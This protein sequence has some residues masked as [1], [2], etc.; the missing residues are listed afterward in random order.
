M[1]SKTIIVSMGLTAIA[2]AQSTTEATL[3]LPDLCVTQ[4]APTVT[5]V[6]TQDSLTTYSYSCSIDSAAVSSASAKASQ[7]R[8]SAQ[9][10]ASEVRASLATML[11][12][13]PKE[14]EKPD[15]KRWLAAMKQ[16]DSSFECYGL[17]AFDACIPWEIT[18]G[19]SFWAVHYT[20]TNVV[21]VEQECT[22][23]DGGVASGPA[24][25]TAS[26]RLDPEIWGDG[27]GSHTETFA[28][29]EVDDFY[30]RNTVMVTM[31]GEAAP[32]AT[33]AGGETGHGKS[34]PLVFSSFVAF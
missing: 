16:R 9:N 15:D 14:S 2:T 24:T 19:P 4:S 18:Q 27:D 11:P 21:G 3:L 29:T 31:G 8:E 22:F 12:K 25:C 23:G 5:V 1:V 10:K 17:D 26:G 28:K 32:Q 6:N 33:T 30:I 7:V 20:A 34:L 13:D